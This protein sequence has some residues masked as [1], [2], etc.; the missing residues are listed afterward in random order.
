MLNCF[1]SEV[2]GVMIWIWELVDGGLGGVVGLGGVLMV[3]GLGSGVLLG[4]GFEER[5]YMR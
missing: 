4:R 2:I 1:F 3:R 5:K